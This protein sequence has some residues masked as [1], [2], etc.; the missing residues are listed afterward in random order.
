MERNYSLPYVIKMTFLGFVGGLLFTLLFLFISALYYNYAFS[1]SGIASLHRFIPVF[2]VIDL[3]PI[4]AAIVS[5]FTFKH[6]SKVKCE[7]EKSVQDEIHK[8]RKLY[9]FVEKLRE[10]DVYADY[11]PDETYALGK[12]IIN[13]RDNLRKSSEEQNERQKEDEQRRWS[14]EGMARFGEILRQNNDDIEELSFQI[15][16]NL[17]NYVGANQSAFYVIE[18]DGGEKVFRMTAAYAYERRK[19]ADKILPWG[20]GLVGACALEKNTIILKK[21]PDSY[22][23]ITSGLGKANPRALILIPLKVNEEVHGVIEIAS[24]SIFEKYQVEFME[25]VAES[26]ATTISTVKINLQTARLLEESRKQAQELAEKEEQMRQNMEELQATQEEATRQSEKFISFSNS[27]NHTLIRADFDVNGTLLYAN[28]KFLQKLEYSANS[29]VEGKNIDLFI[30]KKDRVWFNE[31]W[32]NL[33]KGGKHFEGDMKLLSKT[34]IDLWTIATFTCVRNANGGV[35]KILF[36]G[37]DT[38]EQKKQSLDF[39]GQINALNRSSIKAEFSPTGDLLDANDKF[40]LTLG[41][42][43]N[44]AKEKTIFEFVPSSEKKSL[45]KLWD[46]VIHGIPFEGQLKIV[47][48]QEA[49]RWLRCTFTAANDMYDE[50][51]KVILVA[52]DVTREKIMEQETQLQTEQ[53]KKQEEMLRNNE[54]ELNRKLREAKEE[55]KNQFKEIEK[56]KIRNEKTLEGFLDAIITTDHDGIIQFFNRAAEELFEIKREEVIGQSIRI[57][58]PDERIGND[59]FLDA[60]LNPEKE[61][62]TGQRKEVTIFTKSGNDITVLMLITEAKIGREVTYTAFI[63]NISVDLF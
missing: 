39:E 50:V 48:V 61:K 38:T 53:L 27:V 2:Y 14:A 55:V 31:I 5:F 56:V 10:G 3:L 47:T 15:I 24:F 20:E 13:L 34:G 29:E 30:N 9:R 57:L 60:Y 33:S 4:I 6:I 59:E 16:K 21:V 26:I 11:E 36:L 44:F 40:L 52:Y 49:E 58:F 46:D 45:E 51:A 25:K 22:L 54:V 18:E 19:Y 62:I 43:L 23:N 12:A 8:Q 17:V 42:A 63:Q 28:L 32:K 37:I 41:Y 7:T 35:D 1:A